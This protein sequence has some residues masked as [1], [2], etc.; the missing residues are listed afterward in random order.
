VSSPSAL[1]PGGAGSFLGSHMSAERLLAQATKCV[2]RQ[3]FTA[4]RTCGHP[5]E[6]DPHF[7]A[8]APRHHHP[9]LSRST[10]NLKPSLPGCRYHLQSNRCR[11]PR[12]ASLVRSNMLAGQRLNAKHLPGVTPRL[13][14]PERAP[15]AESYRGN[16]NT[17]GPRALQR[18][19]AM[20]CAENHCSSN[21]SA[22]TAAQSRSTAS[23]T[24]WTAHATPMDGRVAV[25]FPRQGAAGAPI[26]SRATG[27]QTRAFASSTDLD[28]GVFC[29][30]G[31]PTDH[32]TGPST[33]QPSKPGR[34]N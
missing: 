6:T 8:N 12:P 32:R 9:C 28:R 7:E 14:R 33:R 17:I 11:P 31:G 34:Q 26:T 4:A 27:A 2:R 20:R 13:R 30:D 15:A 16:V 21:I 24:L 23:S 1:W 10:R 29:G 22:S 19:K 18:T 3:Y 25:N 5:S